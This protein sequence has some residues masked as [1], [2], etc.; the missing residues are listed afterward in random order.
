MT[1]DETDPDCRADKQR[2]DSGADRPTTPSDSTSHQSSATSQKLNE[3]SLAPTKMSDYDDFNSDEDD[4]ACMYGKNA[5]CKNSNTVSVTA[6]SVSSA[7][8]CG[9]I[10][11]VPLV[12]QGVARGAP[13]VGCNNPHG[14]FTPADLPTVGRGIGRGIAVFNHGER[15]DEKQCRFPRQFPTNTTNSTRPGPSGSLAQHA[16][17]QTRETFTSAPYST[18]KPPQFMDHSV[19]SGNTDLHDVVQNNPNVSATWLKQTL[20]NEQ[21]ARKKTARNVPVGSKEVYC[22]LYH[23]RW[24][25][26][27][28]C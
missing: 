26:V 17:A 25:W 3:H 13:N 7:T 11:R 22:L 4:D 1:K 9:G 18:Q 12:R 28:F 14:G 2:I 19:G 8:P 20:S 16:L 23:F 5:P 27:T 15:L 21:E 6:P 24:A 10:A